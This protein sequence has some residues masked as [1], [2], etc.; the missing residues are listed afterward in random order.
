MKRAGAALVRTKQLAQQVNKQQHKTS[1]KKKF[2]R[3][4]YGNRIYSLT[5][6]QTSRNHELPVHVDNCYQLQVRKTYHLC[7]EK[8]YRSEIQLIRIFCA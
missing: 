7:E 2:R 1:K 3:L 4:E 8:L 6:Q 5:N